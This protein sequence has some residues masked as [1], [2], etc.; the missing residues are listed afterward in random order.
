M[1]T[2]LYA[3]TE[4]NSAFDGSLKGTS[5]QLNGDTRIT[6]IENQFQFNKGSIDL[7]PMPEL[8]KAGAFT[9]E[10][11]INPTVVV[12]SRQNIME[13]QAVPAAFFLDD[14]GFLV[15]S[16]NIQGKGWQ[17]VKSNAPLSP[18]K[19]QAVRFSRDISGAM[20][21]D[22]DGVSV[23]TALV[24]G[25]M[26]AVGQQGF[27]VGTW[28]DGS[29]FQ[30]KGNIGNIGIRNGAFT[31][32][33]WTKR[34]VDARALEQA[35]KAKIGRS[36][37]V[38]PSLDASHARLQP[39]KE[40][41]NAAGVEKIS[42]LD[43]LKITMPTTIARGKVLVAAKKNDT[44]K[45][46][47]SELATQ[48]K[49]LSVTDKKGQLAKFMTNRN[50]ATV[51]KAAKTE[52]VTNPTGIRVPVAVG[53]T[54][55]NR[56]D[57][58]RFDTPPVFRP[59]RESIARNSTVEALRPSLNLGD[60]VR[61]GSKDLTLVNKDLLLKN[62]EAR[63]PDQWPGLGQAPRPLMLHTLPI[64]TSVIIA[65]TLDLTNTQLIISPDVE[66]LYII[67]ENV[68]CGPNAK[69]TWRRPG[70][71][72]PGRLDN[73]DLNGRGWNGVQTKPNSRDGLDGDN[74]QSGESG[75][76]GATGRN[77]PALEMWV[78]NL[79]NVPG[80][81]LNGEDGIQGGRG[82]LGGRGGDGGDGH[83]GH[84][85]WFFG[86]HCDTDPGDGGDGGNGGRGGDGGR[87]GNGG[88][89]GNIVIGV[90]D[91]TLAATV[92]AAQ[93]Q[94][95]NQ[96]GQRGNGGQPGAGGAGGRGGRSGVGETCKDAN[97]GHAGAQGQ[98]GAAGGQGS[99]AGMDA[100]NSFFQF[101][102]DAWDDLMTRP[103]ITEITPQD[104]FPGNT[105]LIRGNRFADTDRV[106]IDGVA[107]LVPTL[108]ADESISV[109]VPNGITGGAKSVFVRRAADGTESNRIPIYIKPL[110]DVLP[111]VLP[112][113]TDSTI[114]GKAFLP[115]ASVLIDGN[116]I[117][118]VV[119][120]AG[121]QI[122]FRMVGTGGMGSSGGSV[123]V[124]VRNPDGLVS[125]SRTA[126][127][128]RILEIP[129]TFGVH[130]LSFSNFTTGV[131]SWGTYEDTF[132]AAE[133]W[134]EQLDPI[135]GHPILTAAYYG[136]YNYFLRGT[137][138]GGLATGFCTSLASLVADKLW[139]GETDAH[140]LTLASVQTMLTAVHGK[141]LSRESLLHFHDQGRQGIARVERTARQIERTFMTGCD[142]NVAPL[143]FFIPSGEVW[144]A[145]YIDKLSSSHC[146]MP[147]RFV[148]PDGHPGP[149][150]SPDGSTTISSLDG[151]KLFCW[152]CNHE[153]S[154]NCRLEFRQVGGVLHYAYFP[155]SV[156]AEFDSTQG[157]VLGHWTNG[158][159]LLADHDLPFGGPFG[160]TGFVI[161]F[162]L[163]PADLEI[164]DENG[165]RV[166]RF[167]DQIFSE[168][169]DSH[170]CYLLKGAYL[171]PVGRNLTR[172][173][174][175]NGNGTYTFNSIM[176]DGTTIK[177]EN[178][179]TQVG[180]RDILMVNADTSQI[181]FA[182]H[183]EKDFTVTISKLINN[184]VRSLAISGVGGGPATEMDITVSPDLSLF[185]LG[186]RSVMKN[187]VVKA[188]AVDKATNVPVNKMAP[189][190]LPT[191][192]DLIVTVGNWNTIDLTVEALGF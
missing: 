1:K 34:V 37:T 180:H 152:D 175:G 177:L 110:L 2:L 64:N 21:L 104:V 130:N 136:F 135:F 115:N 117:P 151:V 153:A 18:G 128:P 161:D 178:V 158:D 143:L 23:G 160:L 91:G 35:L 69:I 13:G 88:N 67:A 61:V 20:N 42:D 181:R 44:I 119:N 31:G 125:N 113:A 40:I 14:K 170:P 89:G 99:N 98:P 80:I 176:P 182:P 45:I 188:F 140:T 121:T 157:I 8:E 105:I 41:M 124:A 112:P 63:N 29:G 43:T 159:Y 55:L 66:K 186:N 156:A 129:F 163:S 183:L 134:H 10:A 16:V 169:P 138:N 24:P 179:A 86:W 95:K 81:D 4:N 53:A 62:V 190:S 111:A 100:S 19:D 68:I 146:L 133:V 56:V 28:V 54:V 26:A 39:I 72:T 114:T 167:N 30:F 79:T 59:S 174:V 12:G 184:Q 107:T 116:A 77:A 106:V 131:P 65:G 173:I 132:G 87:G 71:S 11:T 154:N 52:V 96:G 120:A 164:L 166:G 191:N 144:D 165:L 49:G 189:I 46:N 22:V 147:Y 102:Q 85:Y 122:T 50:S 33:D 185:R 148:Y 84:R 103:F 90:L 57:V 27:K 32:V 58:A 3:R 94:W 150:L 82:Q 36:V 9:L 168:I 137:G 83:V 51:L 93:F 5:L 25:T 162:L 7:G 75:I 92:S 74:G 73:P 38:N 139:K 47:W 172:T 126:A 123:T 70:G 97:D 149:Q 145:G 108:N 192:N 171:L 155:D 101:T 17:M 15:G 109:T 48:F 118:G 6:K 78:K 142:R 127:K 76:N 187:V 141:L 60:V